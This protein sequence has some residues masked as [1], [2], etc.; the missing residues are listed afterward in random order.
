MSD[1]GLTLRQVRFTNKAFWRNPASA[2]FTFAFPLMFLVIFT[3]LFG[4]STVDYETESGAAVQVNTSTFYVAAM[5]AFGV[6]S[7]C[8]TNLAINISFARDLGVLKRLRGSPLPGR[9]FM[10]G[11]VIHAMGIAAILVVLCAAFGRI[12]YDATIPVGADLLRT[13]VA[14]LVGG[15]TFCA[16]GLACTTIIPNADA[17]P[18]IVNA[19]ILPVL[20]L[21]NIFIPVN[22]A[23]A[24]VGFIGK[25]FPVRHFSDAMQSAFIPQAVAWSWIDILVVAAWGVG[26]IVVA[27][28]FF[29]WEPRK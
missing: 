27:T 21:S 20:F 15:A 2:F 14:I 22:D 19:T 7:A 4:T 29:S 25:V 28:W 24:W 3:T 16:L 8:Y 1:L 23:P 11:R 9:V 18:A 5:A 26:G 12:F 17:S 6:I 13:I 10:L